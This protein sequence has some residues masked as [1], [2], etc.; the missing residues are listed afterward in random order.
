MPWRKM[1]DDWRVWINPQATARPSFAIK[2]MIMRAYHLE[3]NGAVKKLILQQHPIPEPGPNEVLVRMHAVSLNRRDTY[4]LN[5]VYPLPSVPG[6]IPLSDG[7]GEVVAIGEAVQKFV[8]GD[9]VTGSYFA[10]WIDGP[11]SRE[12]GCYQLG[13][14]LPGMLTEY[15]LLEEESLVHIPPHL[16]WEEAATLPCAGLTAW[17]ALTGGGHVTPGQTVLTIG[18][19]GVALFALQLAKMLG[20]KVIAITSCPEK[21]AR[22]IE[23]GADDVINRYTIP[24]WPAAVQALTN[25]QGIDHIIETGGADTIEQSLQVAA[26]NAN[27]ALVSV[28]GIQKK[29]IEIDPIIL[30]GNLVTMRRLFVGHRSSL[31]AMIRTIALHM[32][33]PVI[34]RV[35]PFEEA[36][37]AYQYFAAGRLMGK[38][39]IKI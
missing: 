12:L 38:V 25:G 10:R 27:V 30:V 22:L 9:R 28:L 26:L 36:A 34:D 13:C 8:I 11:F 24:N 16:S 15:A 39:V 18:T 2:I 35:F 3:D 23:L 37:L 19:G 32:L 7:A 29:M 21:A 4:I 5:G 1:I 31:E 20:A 33:H 14:T 6:V 17:N